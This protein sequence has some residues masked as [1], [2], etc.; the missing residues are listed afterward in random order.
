[1]SKQNCNSA[2]REVAAGGG[3]T[4]GNADSASSV[5]AKG[6]SSVHIGNN[7]GGKGIFDA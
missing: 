2:M 1:M 5:K 4:H 3:Y 7:Y 6:R